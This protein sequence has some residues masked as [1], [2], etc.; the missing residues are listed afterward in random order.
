MRAAR[1]AAGE[2]FRAVADPTRRGMLDLL[3]ERERSVS[4]LQ[5]RFGV[6]QPAISKH[7][8]ILRAAGLVRARP[9]GRKTYYRLESGPMRAVYE[10]S[11]RYVTDPFGHV[12]SIRRDGRATQR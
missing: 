9:A 11:A 1:A 3:R 10:W 4:E 5:A 6:S 2:V 7:L 8:R 12:W